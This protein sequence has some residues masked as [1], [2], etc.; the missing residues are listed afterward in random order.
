MKITSRVLL[1]A[2]AILSALASL[3]CFLWILSAVSL[4]SDFCG[5]RF[6]LFAEHLRCRQVHFAIILAAVFALTCVYLVYVA[7][8]AKRRSTDKISEHLER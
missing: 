3:Y 1:T 2:G 6:S 5:G 7:A 4:A 8:R